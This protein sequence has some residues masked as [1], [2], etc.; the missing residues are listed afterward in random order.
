M[1]GRKVMERLR[2]WNNAMGSDGQCG[3]ARWN[4]AQREERKDRW[5]LRC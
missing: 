5:A 3:G 2:T 1:T 4:K